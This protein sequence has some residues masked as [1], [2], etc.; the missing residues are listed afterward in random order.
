[1]VGVDV[2]VRL[3][4]GRAI[5]TP[6]IRVHV[7]EKIPDGRLRRRERLPARI[8]GV[9]VDVIAGGCAATACEAAARVLRIYRNPVRGGVAIGA[10]GE[11][12]FGTLA[13]VVRDPSNAACGLTA[14]HVI[15]RVPSRHVIQPAGSPTQIGKVAASVLD[16]RMDAAVIALDGG[17]RTG[18]GVMWIGPVG[19]VVDS[20]PDTDLP[21]PVRMVGACSGKSAGLVTSTSLDIRVDYASGPILMRSQL[22]IV[23]DGAGGEF[24]REGDSGALVVERGGTRA[25]GLLFAGERQ[26]S[27]DYGVATPIRRVLDEFNVAF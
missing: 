2:G 11:T 9:E 16:S 4:G 27:G 10:R 14:H 13:A 1:V 24:S 12:T 3:R 17:R 5:A 22:H 23:A 8:E 20:I 19:G 18:P 21:F 7:V 6:C 25:V 15:V 26:G